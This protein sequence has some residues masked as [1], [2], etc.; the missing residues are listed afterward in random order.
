ML[1]LLDSTDNFKF[2]MSYN[3]LFCS[4]LSEIEKFLRVSGF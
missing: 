2:E 3:F 1:K 4:T